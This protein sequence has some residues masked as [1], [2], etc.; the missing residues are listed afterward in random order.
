MA[1]RRKP[2]H[3]DVTGQRIARVRHMTAEEAEREGWLASEA[4]VVLELEGGVVIY[5][6]C[7]DDANGPG[8]LFACQGPKRFFLTPTE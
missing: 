8:E 6:A 2:H 5:A 3:L 4:A 7:D 1:E